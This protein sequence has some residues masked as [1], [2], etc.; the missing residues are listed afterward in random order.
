MIEIFSWSILFVRYVQRT[1]ALEPFLSIEFVFS[2]R[3]G[4]DDRHIHLG[5]ASQQQ[6]LVLT[7]SLLPYA[8]RRGLMH[9]RLGGNKQRQTP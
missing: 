5:C 7:A 3:L 8:R 1:T 2:C 4:I 6:D 9:A